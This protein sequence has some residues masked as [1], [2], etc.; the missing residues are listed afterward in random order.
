MQAARFTPTGDFAA[1]GRSLLLIAKLFVVVV[2]VKVELHALKGLA[3][4]RDTLDDEV[5]MRQVFE[6]VV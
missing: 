5:K 4:H 1:N 2:T 6:P 3:L